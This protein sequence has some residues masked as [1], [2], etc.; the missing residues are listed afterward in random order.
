[1]WK[2]GVD[3]SEWV[4]IGIEKYQRKDSG[5]MVQEIRVQE[6]TMPPLD[7]TVQP[8]FSLQS[9]NSLTQTASLLTKQAWLISSWQRT[10]QSL[11]I[12]RHDILTAAMSGFSKT[13]R[14]YTRGYAATMTGS[15]RSGSYAL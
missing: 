14:S 9:A 2:A 15:M 3:L 6:I 7:S 12:S 13:C 8:G 5:A 11:R 4:R 10:P 1:M